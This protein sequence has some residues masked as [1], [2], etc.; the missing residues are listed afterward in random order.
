MRGLV[1]AVMLGCVAVAG[2]E[3]KPA[4]PAITRVGVVTRVFHPA[5]RRNWREAEHKELDCTVW[6]PAVDTAVEVKQE[7]GPPEAPLFEAGMAAPHAAMA[8]SMDGCPLVL[9]SHGSGGSAEQMAWLGTALARA[10][11]IAVA[12][13]HPGNNSHETYTAAGFVL[14]WERATDESEV[15]DGMLADEEFGPHID[16]DHVAAAG[17]SIGGYTVLALAGAETDISAFTDLCEERAAAPVTIADSAGNASPA[18]KAAVIAARQPHLDMSTAVCHTKEAEKLGDVRHVL[19]TARKT[20][21][22]SLARSNESYKDARIK[23]V[24]AIAPGVGFTLTQE[25]LHSIRIPVEMVT[26]T[27]DRTVPAKENMDY[28][29]SEIRGARG[30]LIPG[31]THYTFLDTCT[32]EGKKELGIYCEDPAGTDRDAVH[33]KVAGMAV[34]FFNRALRMR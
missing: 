24:F 11:Y 2:A 8:P 27:E 13:N 5:V 20:S 26:G 18:E 7:I 31:A 32:A 28:V 33:A 12:V 17:F 22:E 21:G 30:T 4:V 1:V 14:W 34:G 19:A 16:K 25:S 29:R 15:L 9:L 10:G 3:K 23:A 6:Y